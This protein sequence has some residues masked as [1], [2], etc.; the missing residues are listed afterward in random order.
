MSVNKRLKN[1]M[2]K[3]EIINF[4][5]SSKF[6]LFSDC[7]RGNGSW[8][9]DFAHNQ[10]FFFHALDFYNK[11]DFTYIELGDGDELWENSK[12]AKILSAHSHIFWLLREFYNGKRLYFIWGNHDKERK[13]GKILQKF[14]NDR[15]GE[16]EPLFAGIKVHE[17]LILKHKDFDKTILLVH[18]HQG[19]NTSDKFGWFSKFCVR[20]FW[21]NMQLIGV[22]DPTSPAKNFKK[23]KKLEKEFETWVK[24]NDQ[25]L[26]AGHTHRPV[27][28]ME[29]KP[30][31]FNDGSCVH[32]R[33]ITGI[34]IEN[35]EITLIK[36]WVKPDE[37]GR[38]TITRS[39]LEGPQKLDRYL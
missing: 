9:D 24:D 11:K 23:R 33:C 20:Y 3:A 5:N 22:K 4:D 30:P 28:P 32:L 39:I 6:I 21:K 19:D 25:M 35:G 7:H 13:N 16:I 38:L 29:G 31:Y 17:A 12:F 14:K 15:T 27:F 1:V 2:K 18:G 26:I 37:M 10:N 8:A 36:W 34:E